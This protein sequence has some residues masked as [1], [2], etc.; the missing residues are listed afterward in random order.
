M[1]VGNGKRELKIGIAAK[2]GATLFVLWG[3][4]H[5]WVGAEGIHQYLIG[6]EKNMWNMLIG[7]NLVPKAAFQYTTDAVTAFAQRQLILNFCIDVGG[8]GVLGLAIAF[9]IWKKASWFAYFLGVFI[10]GIAD[11]T[12]LFAMVTAGV[13]ETNMGTIGGPVIWFFAVVITPFGM[14]RLRLR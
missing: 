6:D 11:L 12:F 14:P 3:V 13:I 2:I 10:I 7:G 1:K 8:Y 4:L 5:V 9:L